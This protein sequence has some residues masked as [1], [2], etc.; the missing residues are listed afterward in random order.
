MAAP[1]NQPAYHGLAPMSQANKVSDGAKSSPKT[2]GGGFAKQP[3]H[4]AKQATQKVPVKAKPMKSYS[5][6]D[7]GDMSHYNPN[8]R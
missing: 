8:L 5:E 3:A 6:A 4:V 2:S 1:V 7:M